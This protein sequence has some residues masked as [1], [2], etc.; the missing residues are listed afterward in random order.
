[1]SNHE[2][3][4]PPPAILDELM[5]QR[6]L[7]GHHNSPEC[8]RADKLEAWRWGVRTGAVFGAAFIT[9]TKTDSY[10]EYA[11]FSEPLSQAAL[12]T[13]VD[14]QA[15]RETLLQVLAR[16]VDKHLWVLSQAE[17]PGILEDCVTS[18]PVWE[19]D[20][21]N[22]AYIQAHYGDKFTLGFVMHYSPYPQI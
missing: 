6:T 18:S 20:Y 3:R 10:A 1:M 5:H 16:A 8:S 17:V 13:L 7:C 4:L 19:G 14:D 22:D 2:E 15:A 12:L 21:G 11:V 9:R